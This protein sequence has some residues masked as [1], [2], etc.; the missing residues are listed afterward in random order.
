MKS[1]GWRG[2]G[3]FPWLA[4][5]VA[6]GFFILFAVLALLGLR[7]LDVSTNRILEERLVLAEMTASHIERAVQQAFHE[8]QKA[9]TFAAFDPAASN[10]VEEYH[11]LAHS[12]GRIGTM[13]LGVYFLDSRGKVVLAEPPEAANMD[14]TLLAIQSSL[15]QSGTRKISEPFTEPRTG[16]PTVAVTLAVRGRDGEVRSYLS[17]LIDLSSEV[18]MGPLKQSIR[19]GRTGHAELVTK[20]GIVIA[21]TYTNYF[22]HPGEHMG[23]Y[24]AALANPKGSII[25]TVPYEANGKHTPEMH[26]MALVPL[27]VGGWGLAVG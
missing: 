12:Y 4:A 9:T 25:D 18:I 15:S 10:L 27:S 26:I 14:K 16:H 7:A 24:R 23:F 20:E 22:L 6:G 11:M 19:L 21:S 5:I 3:L 1:K 2:V 13:T 17:G 8:L